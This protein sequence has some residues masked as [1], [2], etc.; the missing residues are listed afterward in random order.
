ME[1][2]EAAGE[3]DVSKVQE[4]LDQGINVNCTLPDTQTPLFAAVENG[5]F[6]VVKLLLD[7]GAT[8]DAVES[9]TTLHIAVSRGNKEI[10]QLLL[11]RG[12]E[13]EA[14]LS[15]GATAL[16]VA[17]FVE[18]NLEIVKLLL[19]RGAAIT[20]ADDR[21]QTVM[22]KAIC[23][24]N[25]EVVQ[26]LL[27]RGAELDPNALHI[28]S[29]KESLGLVRL[30]L[31]RGVDI[32]AV[33]KDNQ[34]ALHKACSGGSKKD[35]VQLLIGRGANI[36]AVNINGQTALV[37]A[38]TWSNRDVAQMLVENG[39]VVNVADIDGDT[40]LHTKPLYFHQPTAPHLRCSEPLPNVLLQL[41]L[42]RGAA[43]NAANSYG[44][45]P[46]LIASVQGDVDAAQSILDRGAARRVGPPY[47]GQRRLTI[48][49]CRG[50]SSTGGRPST[51]R[52]RPDGPRFMSH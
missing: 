30:L 29:S 38:I 35:L 1:L 23:I 50:F 28:A 4:I 24:N 49:A 46:L 2:V 44:E 11:D 14:T 31:D 25:L 34:T 48:S 37:I 27:D 9:Q 20:T 51:P 17:I 12:V 43:V 47:T 22:Y 16:H 18:N 15:N 40:A 21:K 7:R 13:I 26:L 19:D 33:D 39:A 5:H 41:L 6:E 36:D 32:E 52:T 8:L 42:D 10:T 45:T 3:G